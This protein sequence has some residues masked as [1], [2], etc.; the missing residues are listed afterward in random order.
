MTYF[1]GFHG[2]IWQVGDDDEPNFKKITPW[3]E[4]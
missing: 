2:Y 4:S 3:I 1:E